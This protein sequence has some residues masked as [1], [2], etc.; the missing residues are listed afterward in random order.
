MILPPVLF[1]VTFLVV[2]FDIFAKIVRSLSL[3]GSYAAAIG[4]LAADMLIG[5]I[6]AIPFSYVNSMV[7][8]QKYGFN[9][10]TKK[11]LHL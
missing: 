4:I 1:K 8:E 9:K 5:L 3:E 11:D 7:V 10:M 6:Y 2:G